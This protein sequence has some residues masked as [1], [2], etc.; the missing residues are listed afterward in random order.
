M[1]STYIKE[2]GILELY[3]LGELS[4]DEIRAVEEVLNMDKELRAICASIEQN[5][6][7]MAF[8][9]AIDPPSYIKE[10][11]IS[12]AE[13]TQTS[14]TAKVIDLNT[15]RPNKTL[16]YVAASVAALLLINSI[17]MYSNWRSSEENLQVLQE[18][19]NDLK[20]KLS[21]IEN[22][23]ESTSEWYDL[24]ND[25]DVQK[26]TLRG[27][28][29]SPNSVAVAYLNNEN[30]SVVL[31]ASGLEALQADETYQMWADV[32]GE[33]INMGVI[34]NDAGMIAMSFIDKA[35]SLN[36]TIEPAGGS[37]HP[38]VERLITNIYL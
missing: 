16:F 38:T 3:V 13:K 6:E 30:K 7:K 25:P 15:A 36:I 29:K 34:P 5:L 11:L 21:T 31:N 32:E 14:S 33:M 27:N 23:L 10:S 19:T 12:A 20:S 17:W 24:I 1:D 22:E 37:D 2:N 35:E 9:N 28:E 4:P 8:E 18:E 26:F